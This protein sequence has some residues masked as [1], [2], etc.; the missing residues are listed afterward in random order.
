MTTVHS[1]PT[2]ITPARS[3][4][5]DVVYPESDGRS[6]AENTLQFEYIVKIH[7]GIAAQFQDDPNVFVAGDLL[8]YP[9]EGDNRTCTAPDVMVAFGR[10]RGHRRSYL[11]WQE[12]GVAPHVVFEVLSPSNTW[13]EMARK[14]RFYE[15]YGIEEYY[16]Y[17]PDRGELAG[18]LRGGEW[19]EPI[20][21]LQGWVSPRLG[22]RFELDGDTLE[23]FH[24]DGRRFETAVALETQL[25]V[26]RER[27]ERLEAQLR[28]LGVAPE[29]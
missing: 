12:G 18:W 1:L 25:G 14:L 11:Q 9:V 13:A 16:L 24:P 20:E 28:A 27:A 10:P 22:V 29:G 21:N 7:T 3:G 8:W 2:M 26:E 5:T 23:L 15:R 4:A 19:L 6:I 17:D